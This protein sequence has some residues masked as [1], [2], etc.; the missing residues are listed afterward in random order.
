MSE[1][2]LFEAPPPSKVYHIIWNILLADKQFSIT[3]E[4]LKQNKIGHIVAILPSKE[5]YY[6]LINH[7]NF[8]NYHLYI[9]I[10]KQFI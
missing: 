5:D 2:A 1:F 6:K 4:S 9:N 8:I 7:K 10:F 3:D